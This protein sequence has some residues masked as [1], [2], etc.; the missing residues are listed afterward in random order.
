[1]R[2]LTHEAFLAGLV[3]Y[4]LDF[5]DVVQRDAILA[6]Q[7]AVDDEVAFSALGRQDDVCCRAH[8]R[9]CSAHKRREGHLERFTQQSG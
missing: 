2:E 8:W 3:S 5:A 4:A 9:L 6:E 7:P 1:M